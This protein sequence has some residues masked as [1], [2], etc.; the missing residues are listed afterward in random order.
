MGR[1][2]LTGDDHSSL[3]VTDEP[4]DQPSGGRH[5]RPT[6]RVDPGLVRRP[7]S[8]ARLLE[9]LDFVARSRRAGPA[10]G[11]GGRGRHGCDLA[12]GRPEGPGAAVG[13]P[14]RRRPGRRPP[15]GRGHSRAPVLHDRLGR[16]QPVGHPGP[17]AREGP[18]RDVD[19]LGGPPAQPSVA[20]LDLPGR[21]RPHHPGLLP[22]GLVPARGP[23]HGARLPPRARRLDGPGRLAGHRHPRLRPA[24]RRPALAGGPGAHGPGLRRLVLGGRHRCPV[25]PVPGGGRLALGPLRCRQGCRDGPLDRTAG[26]RCGLLR[27]ADA[28]VLP[29]PSGDRR[30][31]RGEAAG[32]TGVAG[33]RPLSGSKWSGCSPP[34]TCRS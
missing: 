31:P 27:Q 15:P 2:P 25:P 4:A 19:G 22:G 24:A 29:S 1:V 20:L 26:P 13:R 33:A 12:R 14:R 17:P 32:R 21:R 6:G 10:P 3:S 23:G 8:R 11:R 28:L 5:P 34:A 30:G 18:V 9:R 7:H 16:L